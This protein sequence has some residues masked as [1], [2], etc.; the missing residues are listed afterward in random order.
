MSTQYFCA[1]MDLALH[2]QFKS[3]I[4]KRIRNHFVSSS[5]ARLDSKMAT[6]FVIFLHI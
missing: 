1:K 2:F 3:V 4:L 5:E 6:V